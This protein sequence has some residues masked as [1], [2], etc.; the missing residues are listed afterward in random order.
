MNNLFRALDFS[1]NYQFEIFGLI[2]PGIEPRT[3]QTQ[4]KCSTTWPPVSKWRS[5]V[6]WPSDEKL[7]QPEKW[8]K[9]YCFAFVSEWLCLL[10]DWIYNN[11]FI[12]MIY[13]FLTSILLVIKFKVFRELKS[14]IH[15]S[16]ASLKWL[17]FHWLK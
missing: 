8:R 11:N 6:Q 5:P 10:F 2:Q 9:M 17:T 16:A 14:E 4:R 3:F 12:C 1:F 7:A 15:L 13:Y